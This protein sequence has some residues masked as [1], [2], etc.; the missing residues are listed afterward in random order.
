MEDS[1]E[2]SQDA[3]PHR[4]QQAREEGQI[5]QSQDL[6]AAVI[7]LA[8]SWGM[9]WGGASFGYRIV[10]DVVPGHGPICDKRYLNE[11]GA[12]IREWV[13]Y[14]RGGVKQGLSREQ[15]VATLTAMT[16]RY[17]MDVGQ[18]GMAPM[19]MKLNIANLYDFVSGAGIHA[20]K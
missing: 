6:A 8:S 9:W 4:R 18:D 15:S 5:V 14:V 13:D 11:Q 10:L 2:K 20:K 17:P 19:V 3:T 7:L 16:E 1:G 12:F